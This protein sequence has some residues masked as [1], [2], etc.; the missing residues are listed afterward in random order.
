MLLLLLQPQS[1]GAPEQEPPHL[2][3]D[4]REQT[5]HLRCFRTVDVFRCSEPHLL[6]QP[7]PSLAEAPPADSQ[8]RSL[9]E[10]REE[11]EAGR[12]SQEVFVPGRSF[13][14]SAQQKEVKEEGQMDGQR[15]SEPHFLLYFLQTEKTGVKH[16]WDI[17]RN[18]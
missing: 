2:Q 16:E 13:E 17:K 14:V 9:Y 5:F 8:L 18:N 10:R 1:D 15:E 7:A 11:E 12:D 3:L 6:V 4:K